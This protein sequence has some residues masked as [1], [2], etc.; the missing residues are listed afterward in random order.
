MATRSSSSTPTAFLDLALSEVFGN[1]TG[2]VAVVDSTWEDTWADVLGSLLPEGGRVLGSRH[3]KDSTRLVEMAERAGLE[4]VSCDAPLG[5]G[6][7]L[8]MF[9]HLL[10]WDPSI[11]AVLVV[12][13]ESSAGVRNDISQVRRVLDETGS[14]ARLLVDTTPSGAVGFRQDEWAVDAVVCGTPSA[15]DDVLTVLSTSRAISVGPA[16]SGPPA[17][18]GDVGALDGTEVWLG[19]S[20]GDRARLRETWLAEGV[21]RGLEGLGLTLGARGPQWASDSVTVCSLPPG[22]DRDQVTAVALV[23]MGSGAWDSDFSGLSADQVR[24]DHRGLRTEKDCLAAVAAMELALPRRALRV[25]HGAGMTATCSWFAQARS[26]A[27][28]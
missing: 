15:A 8:S 4:V 17:R 21:R 7:P 9:S 19:A 26:G 25:E 6:A 27:V 1:R 18:V 16:T 20:P 2:S 12:Q 13:E 3:G 22:T 5:E 11:T 24:L 23:A 14:Q 28:A 10:W